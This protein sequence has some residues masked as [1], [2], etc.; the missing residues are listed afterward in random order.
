MTDTET[1]LHAIT[2]AASSHLD[3]AL[4]ARAAHDDTAV[5]LAI[6]SVARLQRLAARIESG[7]VALMRAQV[8]AGVS[9]FL[10]R[11]AT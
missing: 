9:V 1:L 8:G 3:D 4:H 5:S 11:Q 6:G 7:E 10:Q 2:V